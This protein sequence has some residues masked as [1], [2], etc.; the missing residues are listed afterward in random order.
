MQPEIDE[1]LAWILLASETNAFG[2]PYNFNSTKKGAYAK[3]GNSHTI[4]L[5]IRS[6][7]L[8]VFETLHKGNIISFGGVKLSPA[9][10]QLPVYLQCVAIFSPNQALNISCQ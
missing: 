1:N 3:S 5:S 9:P 8:H 10:F 6:V 2:C 7:S 4:G